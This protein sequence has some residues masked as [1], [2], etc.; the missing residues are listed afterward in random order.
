MRTVG[1][2]VWSALCGLRLEHFTF[3]MAT[4]IVSTAVANSGADDLARVLFWIGLVG[5]GVLAVGTVLGLVRRQWSVRAELHDGACSALAF[6]AAGGVLSA[7]ATSTGSTTLALVLIVVSGVAWFVLQHGVLASLVVRASTGDGP[8]SLSMFDGTWFLLV[9]STQALAV[10]LGAW[11]KIVHTDV[12][13]TLAV[14]A[15]GLGVL[16]LIVIAC[17]VSARLLVVG[18]GRDDDVSPYWVFLGSGAI[19]I[20]GAAEVLGAAYDQILLSPELIG[21]VAM[22]IW[23]FVTWMLLPTVALQVWQELRS[24]SRGRY[25]AALWSAVFPIGMYG[26][27]SRQLGFIRGTSWLDTLGTWEAWVAL[28]AWIAVAL[29]LVSA[30]GGLVAGGAPRW[31]RS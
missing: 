12:G 1:R 5:Y 4:G 16:Q 19:T 31:R 22:A 15:W 20:L 9:V 6:V 10:S 21:G 26:E 29:G 30:I 24:G 27:S 11:S 18:V 8:R 13:A 14:L 28:G 25:R 2:G 17:L 23:A 3:V 7:H